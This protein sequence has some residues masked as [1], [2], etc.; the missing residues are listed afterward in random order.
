MLIVYIVFLLIM[1]KNNHT[2]VI[3]AKI[4]ICAFLGRFLYRKGA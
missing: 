4:V 1:W 3:I 2:A